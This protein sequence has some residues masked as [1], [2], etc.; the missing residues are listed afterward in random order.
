MIIFKDILSPLEWRTTM[1]ILKITKTMFGQNDYYLFKK[2]VMVVG[3]IHGLDGYL[4]YQGFIDAA[5]KLIKRHHMSPIN[6]F[7][8]KDRKMTGYFFG[9]SKKYICESSLNEVRDMMTNKREEMLKAQQIRR[10]PF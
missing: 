8:F 9:V 4:C 5:L 3:F 10:F 6:T 2:M 7:G 1:L